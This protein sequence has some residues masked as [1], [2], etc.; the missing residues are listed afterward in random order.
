MRKHW[1]RNAT[2]SL[3]EVGHRA[4]ITVVEHKTNKHSQHWWPMNVITAVTNSGRSPALQM[5]LHL[6]W[7]VAPDLPERFPEVDFGNAAIGVLGPNGKTEI[8]MVFEIPLAERQKIKAG[9]L[10]LFTFG[11]VRY[12]DIFKV[13]HTTTW[14]LVYDRSLGE[15]T[16]CTK[17]N[18]A[19]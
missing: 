19:T 15:F 5:M 6:D 16:L 9:D 11:I 12:T 18:D 7:Q 4:W 8:A 17:F 2:A 14:Y 13:T 3:V 10:Y 1:L